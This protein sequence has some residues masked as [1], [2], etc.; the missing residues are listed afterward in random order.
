[1]VSKEEESYGLDLAGSTA[2][3][4]RKVSNGVGNVNKHC[5]EVK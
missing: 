3:P 4:F 1:M 2:K 5:E